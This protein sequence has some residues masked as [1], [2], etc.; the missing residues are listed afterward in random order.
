MDVFGSSPVGKLNYLIRDS[1]RHYDNRLGI[2]RAL[3]EGI[4]EEII[5]LRTDTE[6][7]KN[8]LKTQFAL[9]EV[10][11]E[12]IDT[13]TVNTQDSRKKNNT[14]TT[15]IDDN[16]K[17]IDDIITKM[18]SLDTIFNTT[19]SEIEHVRLMLVSRMTKS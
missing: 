8:K 10:H 9:M 2:H 18:K 15:T 7:L 1:N 12:K 6:D 4:S 19:K 3:I 17:K 5:A 13:L 11:S 16:S 14:Q